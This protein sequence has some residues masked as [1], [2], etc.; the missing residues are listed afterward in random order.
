M[1]EDFAQSWKLK[2]YHQ[3]K[4]ELL[5]YLIHINHNLNHLLFLNMKKGFT[6][7]LNKS[8]LKGHPCF[9]PFLMSIGLEADT[10]LHI[11]A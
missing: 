9:T 6:H 8:G 2:S 4:I 11:L 5:N 1:F 7:M 3:P 10:A